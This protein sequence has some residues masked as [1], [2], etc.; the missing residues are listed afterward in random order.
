MLSNII[1]ISKKTK[2]L[3]QMEKDNQDDKTEKLNQKFWDLQNIGALNPLIEQANKNNRDVHAKGHF[4]YDN[5]VSFKFYIIVY[6]ADLGFSFN[7]IINF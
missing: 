1:S 3:R 5:L 4:S 7:R 6:R 2:A